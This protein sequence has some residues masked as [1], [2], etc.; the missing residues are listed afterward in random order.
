MAAA[1]ASGAGVDWAKLKVLGTLGRGSFGHVQLVSDARTGAQYALKSVWKAQIVETQQQ[2]H[3]MSE[4]RVMETL[5][6]PFLNTFHGTF[7][8]RNKL[9]FLLEPCLGGELFTVLRQRRLFPEDAARFYAASVVLAFAYMHSKDTVYRDLK[10]ENL[11]LTAEGY[12]K[13]ADFGFAKKITGK[14]W[15]LCGTPDYLAPEIVASRGHGKGVDWWTLG[16]LIFE[17][18]ASYPPFYDED[19]IRTY[20]KILEVRYLLDKSRSILTSIGITFL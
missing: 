11:M 16:V 18:L 2:G 4:K 3:I 6:H 13:V 15:T 14:T 1:A 19:Q 17:M 9:H 12:L 7:Q 5:Q 10:P 20:N 8:S